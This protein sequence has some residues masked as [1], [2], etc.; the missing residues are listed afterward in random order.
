MLIFISSPM[1][2]IE[3]AAFPTPVIV[4][5]QTGEEADKEGR[6]SRT[7]KRSWSTEETS[8]TTGSASLQRLK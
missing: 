3:I 1:R 4:E 7:H 2:E 8:E 5:R 6:Q